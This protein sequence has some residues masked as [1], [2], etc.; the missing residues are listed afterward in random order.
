MTDIYF[1]NGATTRTDNCVA[2]L[3]YDVMVS[4]YGN[5]SS[6]HSKGLEA[7]RIVKN[8]RK[9][10]A[11]K[12]NANSDE[13]IF[14]ASGSEANNL[15]IIGSADLFRFKGEVITSK[16]EHKCV[17]ECF[18]RLEDMGFTVHYIDVDENGIVDL[19][20]LK[21]TVNDNTQLVSIM[22]VNNECGTIQPIKEIY[23]TI[24]SKNSNTL[25]HTD[26]IQGF[27]KIDLSSDY[28]DMMS[29][30]AH[31]ING[32]KGI[33]ALYVKKGIKLSPVIYG[34]GQ[35]KGLRGGTENV[36]SIAGFGKAVEVFKKNDV[37][38]LN[39]KKHIV[40]RITAEVPGVYVNGD[41]ENDSPYILNVAM[42][43]LRSEIILHSLEQRGIYVSSGSACSS[44]KP[45]P[46]HVLV[47]MGYKA[48]RVDSSIRLSFNSDNTMEEA[49]TFCD[50][51]AD[52]A[53]INKK[54][55]RL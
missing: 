18:K 44:N 47:A 46:S 45:S 24:K 49:D 39:I 54:I 41:I 5:P 26:N 6:L 10:I 51:F 29:I 11:D 34:G 48:D 42:I 14:T 40:K 35:E 2:K 25:F 31:K 30:S 32:P 16:V 43:G 4:S 55:R 13:I 27:C 36:P 21:N 33:G 52:I 17:L 38:L 7:E 28:C 20:Q 22:H 15:A 19:Q 53:K 37:S 3:M 9:I 50:A 23:D 8:A 12:I 1:D